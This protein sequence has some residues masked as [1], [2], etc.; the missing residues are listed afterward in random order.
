VTNQ[1]S[2]FPPFGTTDRLPHNICH[3]NQLN[4]G[5]LPVPPLGKMCRTAM[6][7]QPSLAQEDFDT[8][9]SRSR[10]VTFERRQ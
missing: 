4:W 8:M 9:K 3:Q 6:G 7:F 2:P 1:S 5:V 10:R